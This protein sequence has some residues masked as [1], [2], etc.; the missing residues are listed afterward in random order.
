MLKFGLEGEK[1]GEDQNYVYGVVV[2]C[3]RTQ[4]AEHVHVEGG[5]G[6]RVEQEAVP[7]GP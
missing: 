6:C 1:K 7:V 4:E 3:L 5:L 2:Q